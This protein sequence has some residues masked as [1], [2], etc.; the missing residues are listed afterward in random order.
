TITGIPAEDRADASAVG[1]TWEAGMV[2]TTSASARMR[3]RKQRCWTSTTDRVR[4][5]TM[6]R[7]STVKAAH[8]SAGVRYYRAHH[9]HVDRGPHRTKVQFLPFAAGDLQ[10]TMRSRK[11]G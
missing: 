1:T 2:S 6:I 10:R 9:G 5:A 8:T 3:V 7:P 11:A 4:L